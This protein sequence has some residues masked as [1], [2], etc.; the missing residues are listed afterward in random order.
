[1]DRFENRIRELRTEK[2][3]GLNELARRVQVSGAYI[4]DIELGFRPGS[5]AV[6]QRI[7]DELG[8]SFDD[9]IRKAG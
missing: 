4:H 3:I 5:R 6:L 2:G 9:L 1:M 7:A 8:V